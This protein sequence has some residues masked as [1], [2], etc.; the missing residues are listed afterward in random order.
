VR[1]VGKG[2]VAA[3]GYYPRSILPQH[4]NFTGND[5][6]FNPIMD[7][8]HG[9][10]HGKDFDFMEY[11]Y[12]MMARAILW[13]AGAEPR[14]SAIADMSIA[15]GRLNIGRTDGQGEVFAQIRNQWDDVVLPWQKVRQGQDISPCLRGGGAFRCD[16]QLLQGE[17]IA[18]FY[19]AHASFPQPMRLVSMRCDADA[20]QNGDT[21]VCCVQVAGGK[22]EALFALSDGMDRVLAEQTVEL[23]DAPFEVRFPLQDI[24]GIHV[25]VTLTVMEGGLPV[26]RGRSNRVVVTPAKRHL[27]DFEIWMNPQNRG[28]G[29]MLPYVNRLFPQIGMTGNLVGDNKLVAMSGGEGLGVY[30]YKRAGYV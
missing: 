3:F 29:D 18:D 8:W 26:L 16:A 25:F 4:K 23:S 2:R 10:E 12:R 14:A 17:A 21:L 7:D 11:F 5:A 9:A 27:D 30:W 13:C 15:E 6:C 20:L 24:L 22:G 28:M 19:T 1:S